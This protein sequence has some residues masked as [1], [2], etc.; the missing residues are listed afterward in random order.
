MSVPVLRT[1]AHCVRLWEAI[2]FYHILRFINQLPELSAGQRGCGGGQ[3]ADLGDA[4]ASREK[5]A[6]GERRGEGGRRGEGRSNTRGERGRRGRDAG[7]GEK[8]RHG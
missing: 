2:L 8:K 1:E 5:A 6:W 3:A 7:N 4:G